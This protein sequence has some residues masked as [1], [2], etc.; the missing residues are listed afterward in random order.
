M[1]LLPYG[2]IAFAAG[3]LLVPSHADALTQRRT[4]E[5]RV[6]FNKLSGTL[7][8]AEVR[9]VLAA[10]DRVR[11]EDWCGSWVALLWRAPAQTVGAPK[12]SELTSRRI[13]FIEA[14]LTNSGYPAKRVGAAS[15]VAMFLDGPAADL[16][17]VAEGPPPRNDCPLPQN[18]AGFR[19]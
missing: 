19:E 10:V 17:L 5:V 9:K 16:I 7:P 1:K 8:A 2:L 4:E 3:L 11:S 18:A 15:E 13:A 12:P 14:L 6:R